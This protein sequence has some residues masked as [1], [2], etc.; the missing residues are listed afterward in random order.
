VGLGD[1]ERRH[2]PAGVTDPKESAIAEARAVLQRF[3][4]VEPPVPVDEIARRLGADIQ[5]R[6]NSPDISGLLYREEGATIVI[7]VNADDSPVRQRFTIAH[8]LGHLQMHSGTPLFVDRSIRVNSRLTG[9]AGRGGEERQANWFAA[10]LLMPETMVRDTAASFA[11]SRQLSDDGLVKALAAAF[12]VS[13]IA[14]GYRLF[15][16]GLVNGL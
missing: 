16:L 9:E 12:D 6:A 2:Q 10:E 4:V 8:E 15:N 11:K 5:R 14:M 3:G 1:A 7:G 13:R